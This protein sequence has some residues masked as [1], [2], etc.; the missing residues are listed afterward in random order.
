MRRHLLRWPVAAAVV[1]VVLASS[2]L[3]ALREGEVAVVTRFGAP[4]AVVTE[5]G[6]HAKWPWPV[7]RIYRIDAR[8]RLFNSRFAETL[9]QDKKNIIL[10]TFVVWSVA[11][12]L[13][14]LQS[15]GD[16]TTAE[17]RLDGLVTNAKNAV[18]G[19]CPLAALVSTEP[20][21]LQVE[22]VEARILDDVETTALKSYGIR[23]H[24]VGLKQLGLPSDNV[25]QIF[26]RMR[27]EREKVAARYRA[28]GEREAARI[29]SDTD[30]AVARLKADGRLEALKIRGA[31]EA[32][33]ARI[34]REAHSRD[35]E[36]YRFL[37]RIDALKNLFGERTSLVFRS[38]EPPFDLLKLRPLEP[39]AGP[40]GPPAGPT[41]QGDR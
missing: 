21:A 20:G 3:Y 33:A 8:K 19:S 34:Y 9:T 40:G 10:R 32:E 26:D 4:R 6:L 5:A 23:V 7:E 11:D 18:L 35:P 38:D 37:R 15:M 25:P 14:F 39:P 12:A 27:A 17:A 13:T 30:L 22:A 1:A 31:A 28:E 24:Q 41:E 29:R 16:L 2:V 36:F